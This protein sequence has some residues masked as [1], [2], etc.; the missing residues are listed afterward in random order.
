MF[1]KINSILFLS[2]SSIIQASCSNSFP[3]AFWKNFHKDL[4]ITSESNYGA[5]GWHSNNSLE[6]EKLAVSRI[7]WK[8][9]L[10]LT[11][12]YKTRLSK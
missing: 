10:S 5:W 12:K 2:A 6:N 8:S 7:K 4:I 1:E 3:S 11:L 9:E